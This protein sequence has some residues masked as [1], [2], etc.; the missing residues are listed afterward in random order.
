MD[1]FYNKDE[2][3]NRY[4]SEIKGV[5]FT[6]RE[7]DVITCIFHNRGSKKI[8]ALLSISLKT[9]DAHFYN[10]KS[11]LSKNSRDDVIDFIEKSGKLKYIKEYYLCLLI[12]FS[13][14]KNLIKI[15][16]QINKEL[17]TY[18]IDDLN[19][20]QKS[21][22]SQKIINEKLEN[23][24][25]DLKLANVALELT[26]PKQ[27][28]YFYVIKPKDNSVVHGSKEIGLLFD[29]INDNKTN[30]KIEY[31]DFTTKQNYYF[32]VFDL[33]KLILENSQIEEIAEEFKDEYNKI[34]QNNKEEISQT[35]EL[36]NATI[37][38]GKNVPKYLYIILTIFLTI[39]FA[40]IIKKYFY[41]HKEEN[42]EEFPIIK[43]R[44][45]EDAE[46]YSTDQ[47]N[48]ELA[49][50][51]NKNII[52]LQK[53]IDY[54]NKNPKFLHE[55][56]V[57]QSKVSYLAYSLSAHYRWNKD[58]EMLID[59]YL[60]TEYKECAGFSEH[61]SKK[62]HQCVSY[63][64]L[65]RTEKYYENRYKFTDKDSISLIKNK[66]ERERYALD[67]FILLSYHKAR[68]YEPKNL[69]SISDLEY[70]NKYLDFVILNA[71]NDKDKIIETFLAKKYKL[72]IER[73]Y[74]NAEIKKVR[75]QFIQKRYKRKFGKITKY[76]CR[77]N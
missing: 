13:F 64:I 48:L 18:S 25:R 50:K 60:A 41:T 36:N 43:N 71:N 70:V 46:Y 1:F 72:I 54:F 17:I 9:V 77:F 31:I 33:L 15:S 19:L 55:D 27:F 66:L 57:L 42:Y 34:I 63:S 58:I 10:I 12:N 59:K 3:Y 23:L 14:E 68:S 75:T 11:K 45:Q 37:N 35:N 53:D 21:E 44:I 24:K 5:K 67:D 16:K 47:T 73:N 62:L 51:N 76:Q 38:I 28:V 74:I 32:G 40:L 29:D 7:I 65:E 39:I 52:T 2:F 49:R 6:P 61:E 4:L 26:T 8:A 22:N 69:W 30:N 20:S 56:D